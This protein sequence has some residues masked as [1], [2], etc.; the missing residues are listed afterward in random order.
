MGQRCGRFC[1]SAWDGACVNFEL[2]YAEEREPGS[3]LNRL[4]HFIGPDPK[5]DGHKATH[6]GGTVTE[7]ALPLE[8]DP[9]R[10]PH[11][12]GPDSGIAEPCG[13]WITFAT[14]PNPG[15]EILDREG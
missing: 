1:A 8:I 3:T 10:L 14:G 7:A 9:N 11:S 2:T 6:H 4:S 5:A 15:A 13:P 12:L